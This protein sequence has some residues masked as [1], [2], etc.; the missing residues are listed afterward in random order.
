MEEAASEMQLQRGQHHCQTLVI[1]NVG[2][3]VDD[4][5][6]DKAFMYCKTFAKDVADKLLPTTVFA[7]R[8]EYTQSFY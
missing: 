2:G 5:E 4:D 3:L 1:D 8:W 7:R 6:G